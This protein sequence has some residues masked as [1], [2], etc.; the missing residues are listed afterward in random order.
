MDD[1][2]P[3]PGDPFAAVSGCAL[4]VN[5][6]ILTNFRSY[7]RGDGYGRQLRQPIV[8]LVMKGRRESEHR[9]HGLLMQ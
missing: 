6:V 7:A 9:K 3:R 1:A 5:H 4:A 2:T 8:L